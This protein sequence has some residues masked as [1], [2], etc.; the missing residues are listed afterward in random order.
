M[1]ISNYFDVISQEEGKRGHWTL[2][3]KT[4]TVSFLR[5]PGE[6][7][8]SRTTWSWI[9]HHWPS[10]WSKTS[11]KA[12]TP[13][14]RLVSELRVCLTGDNRHDNHDWDCR[15]AAVQECKHDEILLSPLESRNHTR[16]TTVV[17]QEYLLR[18][19]LKFNLLVQ[20]SH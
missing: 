12:Q 20:I 16:F 2:C 8:L 14:V 17:L 13:E 7:K 18:F 6:T 11:F 15:P 5:L 1:F 19:S 4:S 3:L 10:F 9:C